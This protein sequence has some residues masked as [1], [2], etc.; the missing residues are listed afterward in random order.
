MPMGNKKLRPKIR[1]RM[2]FSGANRNMDRV[3]QISERS[4]FSPT[5]SKKPPW[6]Q[7]SSWSGPPEYQMKSVT[8]A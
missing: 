7:P 2:N 4:R 1:G 8:G 5:N 6:P 3:P